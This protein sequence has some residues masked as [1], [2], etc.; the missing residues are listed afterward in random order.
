[1]ATAQD[2]EEESGCDDKRIDALQQAAAASDAA[3]EAQR[4]EHCL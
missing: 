3:R 4:Q 2:G 1:M